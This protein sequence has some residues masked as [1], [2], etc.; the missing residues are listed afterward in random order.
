MGRIVGVDLHPESIYAVIAD[1]AA[2]EAECVEFAIDEKA[3]QVF[4]SQ[5]RPDDRIAIEATTNAYYF[6]GR[7]Q[8]LVA[9]V[10]VANPVKLRPWLG[11]AD[12]SDRYDATWLAILLHFGCLPQIHVP[13]PET[14][15]DRDVVAL[16]SSLM[17]EQTRCK[18]GIRSFLVKKGLANP[19]GDL[20]DKDARDL[21]I[22]QSVR[23][24][25]SA[26]M[27][28]NS[29][30]AALDSVTA[31]L[32]TIRP[33]VHQRA[34]NRP[35]SALLLTIPGIELS[36]V[37]T[38]M[39]TIDTIERFPKPGSLVKYAGL[40]PR[41]KSSAGKVRRGGA[42]R[43]GSRA[44]RWAA[45]QAALTAIKQPGT[46]RDL[47]RRLVKKGHAIAI[48]ACARKM[49]SIVWHLL[50]KNEPFRETPPA[51]QK[52]KDARVSRK[53]ARAKELL[54]NRRVVLEDLLKHAPQLKE[55]AG[56]RQGLPLSLRPVSWRGPAKF[57]SGT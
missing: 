22:R 54:P 19:V 5:L 24:G 49:L 18:N 28:L 6:H 15:E 48:C 56:V 37:L 14:R 10:A 7:W 41:E 8:P 17:N 34:I 38:M 40:V 31:R 2:G 4:E 1:F 20:R 23:L 39:A 55:L 12:K 25:E 52:R 26:K 44:L 35:E 21:V 47:Y 50:T 27:V 46:F 16:I 42:K 43:T 51:S 3:L 13:D 45:T 36:L 9:E 53:V 57:K 29:K 11:D 32:D 30:L 33:L